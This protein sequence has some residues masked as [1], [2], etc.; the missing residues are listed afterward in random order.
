MDA[1]Q[2]E[3]IVCRWA[4]NGPTAGHK[5]HSTLRLLPGLSGTDS[6]AIKTGAIALLCRALTCTPHPPTVKTALNFKTSA[7]SPPRR[8]EGATQ[9]SPPPSCRDA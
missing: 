2:T 1:L 5:E 7:L 9:S 3:A 6:V 8:H 4:S